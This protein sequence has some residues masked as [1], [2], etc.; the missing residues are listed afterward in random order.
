[1]PVGGRFVNETRPP[2]SLSAETGRYMIVNNDKFPL[3]ASH[4]LPMNSLISRFFALAGLVLAASLSLAAVAQTPPALTAL[5]AI[6]GFDP[7]AYFTEGQPVL[8][9]PE[10]EH[11][12]DSARYRFASA[13]NLERFKADP[14]RYMPQFAG[15]CAM[16]MAAGRK[17]V[18]D[19]N[20][21]LVHEGK[22]YVFAGTA[23]PD[24]FR[25]NPSEA[26]AKANQ[27]WAAFKPAAN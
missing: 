19:P 17:L 18:A 15:A 1:M 22:L 12:V 8:G 10:F 20:N 25:R 13:E 9:K 24:N 11:S 3:G 16:S 6:K 2:V 21:W 26:M 27:H 5:L 14:D 23:G 7:V 4:S